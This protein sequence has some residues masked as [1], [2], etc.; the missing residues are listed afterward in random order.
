M[1]LLAILGVNPALN[2]GK[3]KVGV[4]G[5]LAFETLYGGQFTL[6]TQLIKPNYLV[7]HAESMTIKQTIC[8]VKDLLT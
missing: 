6:S 8:R 5:N 2:L 4:I 7:I 3:T 1:F